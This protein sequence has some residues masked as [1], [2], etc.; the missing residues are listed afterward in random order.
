MLTL[1]RRARLGL[2]ALT[3]VASC[4]AQGS[5]PISKEPFGKTAD[6][7]ELSLYTLQ[8]PSG[9]KVTITN[10]G[11]V[12]TTIQVPDRTGK[13]GDVVLGYENSAPYLTKE[14]NNYFGALVGRYGNRLAHGKFTIDGHDYQVPINDGPNALHGGPVGFNSKVWDAKDVSSGSTP[15]LEL[16]Y[17]SPDGEMGFPGNLDATVRYTLDKN[18]LHIDYAATTDKA[19]VLNLTNHSY[20][21]LAGAGAKSVLDHKVM[22]AADRFTPVDETLIP[23]GALEPVAGT[24][25]DFRKA[26]PIGARIDT[27]DEQIKRGKG[28]DHNY[29]LNAAGDIRKLAARVEEPTSGRILEV[30]TDQPGLQ[31][32]SGNFLT[33]TSKGI[34]GVYE[35]RSA[36]CMETQ[37]FPDS[38]NHP[39]FP[40]TL[41]KP[42]QKFHST[43]IF[44]FSAK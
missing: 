5:K 3:T 32:Y 17:K 9:M 21:N 10:F 37:H 8:S 19:T 42:G 4:V 41:L 29:V 2:L 23:T 12:I 22:I 16:H 38:P 40:T 7:H 20:F 28:Y 44:R 43:T 15:I 35:R 26:M 18:S 34:G 27:P 11:G 6:G 13:M 1:P 39:S 30:F 36:F 14:T 24:P 25:L 33:G 31:F